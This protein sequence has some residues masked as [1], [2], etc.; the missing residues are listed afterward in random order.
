VASRKEQKEQLKAERL[1]AERHAKAEERRKRFVGIGVAVALGIAAVAVIVFVV[2]TSGGGSSGNAH[3]ANEAG[4]TTTAKAKP[5]ERAGTETEP[6]ALATNL[7]GSAKAAGCRLVNPADEGNRHLSPDE[8]TPKYKSNPPTSGN[9]DPVPLADGAY[10]TAAPLRN[11]VHSMEHGRV[12]IQY[13]PKLP[14]AAQL[15]LKG[16][17]DESFR[18]TAL[19]PNPEMPYEVAATAWG[20][21]LGCPRYSEKALDAVRAFGDTYIG[22]GPEGVGS[23]PSA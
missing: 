6:G 3:I 8:P 21:L 7:D 14:P 20:H 15:K 2:A 13:S 19:F 18:Y 16:V 1:E 23:Q 9:H 5:D 22:Q 17:F 11:A 10:R 12:L 4:F